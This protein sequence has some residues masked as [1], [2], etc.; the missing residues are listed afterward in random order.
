MVCSVVA[1]PTTEVAVTEPH[2][3]EVFAFA[4]DV[5]KG[6]ALRDP[7]FATGAGI[8]DYDDQLPDFSPEG[9]RR[10]IEPTEHA[11]RGLKTLVAGDDID[12]LALWVMD[13]RLTTRLSLLESGEAE[14]V[15]S[16]ISSPLSE[17]RQVFE[18]MGSDSAEE[19]DV[20]ARRLDQV[21]ASLTSWR[22]TIEALAERGELPSR[23]HVLG[24]AD[25][26]STYANGAF[27]RFAERVVPGLSDESDLA[28]AARRADGACGE[29]S[30][31]LSDIVAA[32]AGE[33]DA[34]GRE[35][36]RVWSKNYNGAELDFEELY[37]WGWGDLRRI[38]ARMWEIA[39]ELLP[40][41]KSLIEVFHFLEN[42]PAG[43]VHGTDALLE[44]LVDFTK[45]SVE[46][47]D[48]VHFDIDPRI[49]FCDARLA[50]EGSAAA[51]YY[52]PPSEDLSRPGTTWYPTLGAMT[53]PWWSIP[54][55]WYHEGVPGHHLQCATSILEADR[56]SRFHRLEAWTSGY[57]E[58]W[59]LYGERLMDELGY[60]EDL[61]EEMGFLSSQALRA[62]RVM[63]DIGLHLQLPAPDDIGELGAL[64][65]CAGRVWTAEM[66]VAVLDER[67]LQPHEMSVSEVERYLGMP[68]QAIS[69]KVGERAWMRA[70]E[71]AKVRLGKG[72][73]L[74]RF[75]AYALALGPLGLDAL[76][77]ELRSWNGD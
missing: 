55:T 33:V 52:I 65:D 31:W 37:A 3:S 7:I 20:I 72:F 56:Q 45:R 27:L 14:R 61:G 12:R 47:L 64:G 67:A 48:G 24:I 46:E 30:R 39:D 9:T 60:F 50:P 10:H 19:R 49:R 41:A 16:V 58:G 54:S 57:G 29:L 38:S 42:D 75:H 6:D 53:F 40:G 13:E 62:A 5:V 11:L 35:R 43:Q 21:P 8:T 66:A 59:A 23:R 77:E 68:A 63:V 2:R 32:R 28:R 4:D 70:R 34:C 44:R 76:E 18:L 1:S 74:K 22:R 36:Y 26:A 25:Q 71:D 73:S 15:F 51:P 69:Y 17:I